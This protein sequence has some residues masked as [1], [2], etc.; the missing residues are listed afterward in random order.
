MFTKDDTKALK[1]VAVL[2]MLLHHM[3]YFPDRTPLDFSGFA[4]WLPGFVEDGWL[5][6]MALGAL[7]CV[8]MFFFLGGYGLCKRRRAG[9]FRLTDAVWQLYKKYWRVFVIF[10]PLGLL[11]FAQ[12]QDALRPFCVRFQ[13]D[14]PKQLF[15]NLLG[16]FLGYKTDFNSEW[17]FLAAY[18]CA[19]PLG[20][21]FLRLIRRHRSFLTDMCLVCGIDILTQ[22]VFPGLARVSALSG[23]NSNL[24]F[25]RFCLLNKYSV[26]FFAGIVFAKYDMIALLKRRV[27]ACPLPGLAALAGTAAALL[28]RIYVFADVVNADI[29]LTPALTVFLSVLLDRLQPVR[30]GMIF[31]GRRS[32]D[33]WLTHSFFCYY[34]LPF[35]RLVYCTRSVWFDWAVL[36]ALSLGTSI[37]LE[38]F[39]TGL[40]HLLRRLSRRETVQAP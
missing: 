16:S 15:V 32:T 13:Y 6:D 36:I 29:V 21:L 26:C 40:G 37:L 27:L 1:G 23:L 7:V 14:S 35:T 38:A 17:W 24:Y 34:F 3:A 20:L 25:F 33:M 19:L 18:L 5:N 30:S 2:L 22:G 12:G 31:V 28:C 4:S 8:P 39:Y 11:F 9:Q 10:V